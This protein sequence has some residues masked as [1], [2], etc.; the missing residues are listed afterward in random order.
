MHR[1]VQ[2]LVRLST[3]IVTSIG[4]VLALSTPLISLGN[5][6]DLY[7]FPRNN[8]LEV[9]SEQRASQWLHSI[10]TICALSGTTVLFANILLTRRLPLAVQENMDALITILTHLTFVCHVIGFLCLLSVAAAWKHRV[11]NIPLPVEVR[12]RAGAYGDVLGLLAAASGV[13]VGGLMTREPYVSL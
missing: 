2:E 8:L 13:S 5:L 6:Y 7:L 9:S 11:E 10:A 3:L 1:R 12:L 4:L